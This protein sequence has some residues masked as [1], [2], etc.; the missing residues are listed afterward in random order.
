MHSISII[1]A[2]AVGLALMTRAKSTASISRLRCPFVA[3]PAT[4]PPRSHSSPGALTNYSYTNTLSERP[5][6]DADRARAGICVISPRVPKP[7]MK[8]VFGCLFSSLSRRSGANRYDTGTVIVNWQHCGAWRPQAGR[9]RGGSPAASTP[10]ESRHQHSPSLAT[11][12]R[13][14]PSMA[15]W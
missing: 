7:P 14:E 1:I 9:E 2:A 15:S 13:H 10:P 12:P 5:S 4:A 8:G 6:L 11:G 3:W